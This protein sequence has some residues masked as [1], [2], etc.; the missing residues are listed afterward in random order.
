MSVLTL[1][2]VDMQTCPQDVPS[3]PAWFA[4]LVILA[5]HFSQRGLFDAISTHVQLARGR[6]GTYEVIDFVA[7]LLGYAASGEATLA[8]FFDRLAPFAR[9]FMALFGRDRLPHRS[10]LSRFLADVDAACLAALRQR[11]QA[12]LAQHGFAGEQ[13]GGF[14]DRHGQRLIVFDVDGTRQAARQR[15]LAASV[16]LPA[17]QRRMEAVCAPGSTG[18]KRGEVVRTRT[19]MLQAHT[20]EWLG[21]FSGAGNGDSTGELEAA[22]QVITAYLAAR[23]LSPSQALVRLDGW[24]GT[25][26]V[27]AR[28]QPYQVG[29]LTRGRDYHLLD[30]P[31]VQARLQQPCDLHLTH[32]ETQVQREVFEVGYVADWLEERPDQPFSYRVIRT[33]HMAP[34]DRAQIA[35]GKLRGAYVYELLLTSHPATA[36]PAATVLGLYQQRGAFE[37]VLSDEDHEQDPDRWCS[38][39][40]LGQEFWQ[41][42]CQW[43]WN[44]RLE[45]GSVGQTPVLRWTVWESAATDTPAS[46]SL[47]SEP[48]LASQAPVAGDL[49]ATYGPLALAQPWAKARRPFSAQ[50]CTL[51]ADD[52]LACPAGKVLRP[53]ERRKLENGD[54]RILYAA[55]TLDCR[56]CQLAPQ[57]LGRSASGEPPR[58]VSG[59]RRV[60]GWQ[61]PA[62]PVGIYTERQAQA[63]DS[64]DGQGARALQWGDVG[65]RRLRRDLVALRRRQ[66]VTISGSLVGPALPMF[67]AGARRWTRAERAHR[68]LSWASRVARNAQAADAPHYTATVCGIAPPL[69]AY[70]GLPSTPAP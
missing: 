52:T 50:D 68:R 32:L 23:G 40:P 21:T 4:E 7:V 56:A 49:V 6:A 36:L 48:A 17:P 5:R 25:T 69:A 57:C 14:L 15:A 70:L 28:M 43:V 44:T 3:V 30:H 2:A 29:F 45:L 46:P 47:R 60:V 58:R 18:R 41:I 55:K 62:A 63:E 39:T 22:C 35:V 24:Y 54:L 11:F 33:R 12:D 34:T 61:L 51:C 59:V 64:R 38:R 53:R 13:L 8:A 20:Q 37:Q 67:R 66:Q 26:A 31:T 1:P 19:T 65:G 16:D 42:V 9:P 10:S 27:L